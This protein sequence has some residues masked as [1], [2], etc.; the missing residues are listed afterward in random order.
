MSDEHKDEIEVAYLW[1]SPAELAK[2]RASEKI[3]R[4]A[5]ML[6][7]AN[8]LGLTLIVGL[9]DGQVIQAWREN[10]A[11]FKARAG[12]QNVEIED[13]RMPVLA[14]PGQPHVS[15]S[16]RYWFAPEHLFDLVEFCQDWP[17]ELLAKCENNATGLTV[18][19]LDGDIVDSRIEDGEAFDRQ[20]KADQIKIER[21]G[22]SKHQDSGS[23]LCLDNF[24]RGQG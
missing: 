11:D 10:E 18:L 8:Y 15:H 6:L 14:D 19:T 22:R 9:E 2:L 13:L 12:I 16:K 24:K 5:G 4:D 1:V 20:Q 3:S 17:A 23:L 7:I 21:F